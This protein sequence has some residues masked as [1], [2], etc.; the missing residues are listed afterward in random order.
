VLVAK[1][2]ARRGV[3]D[4]KEEKGETFTVFE[5]KKRKSSDLLLRETEEKGGDLGN[6]RGASS[7]KGKGGVIVFLS[8]H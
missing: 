2:A 4:T 3:R 5:E 7:K 8:T 1:A 6:G